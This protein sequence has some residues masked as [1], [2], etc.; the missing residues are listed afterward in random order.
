MADEVVVIGYSLPVVDERARA[1]LLGTKNKTVRLSICCGNGTVGIEQEFRDH[2][3]T[4]LEAV[5][6]TFEEF[7]TAR[8]GAACPQMHA[9]VA[10]EPPR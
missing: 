2:G 8:C 4:G 1:L 7:L 9:N 5:A 6:P 10:D 3:F